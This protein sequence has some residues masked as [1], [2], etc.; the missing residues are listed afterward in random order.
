MIKLLN[1]VN[2]VYL[3]LY[4][5]PVKKFC[6]WEPAESKDAVKENCVQCLGPIEVTPDDDDWTACITFA[7]TLGIDLCLPLS[8]DW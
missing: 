5:T 3:A 4:K 2:V 6:W 7:K 8:W 1:N